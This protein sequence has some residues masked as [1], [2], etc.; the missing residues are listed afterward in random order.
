MLSA[1]A[2]KARTLSG[3]KA[4]RF[5]ILTGNMASMSAHAIADFLFFQVVFR[6]NQDTYKTDFASPLH[7]QL[8]G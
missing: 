7:M 4:D 5:S 6:A 3:K 1:R 8:S 2:R